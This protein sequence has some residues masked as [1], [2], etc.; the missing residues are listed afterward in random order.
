MYRQLTAF[1]RRFSVVGAFLLVAG[2]AT[3]QSVTPAV[4]AWRE[5][6]EAEITR[7]L[8]AFLA[9][10]NVAS[11]AANIRRNA[12]T[13]RA[14]LERR[15][16]TARLLEN[17][18]APPAVF[19]ELRAP[20]ATRTVMFYAHYDGQ[21]VSA[22]EWATP[23]WRPVLRGPPMAGDSLA[24]PIPLPA[25]GRL[26]PEA[27]LYARSASDDKSPIIAM[28]AALDALKAA[29]VAP[30][31]NL[32]FFFEGEEEAG[33]EHLRPL[34]ERNARLLAADVWLFCDGPVHQSRKMQVVF[35]ARGVMGLEMTVYGPSRALHSG[36]YGNWAPNPGAL[37]AE[38]IASMRDGDGN[39][40]IERFLDDVVP[41]TT[42]ERA[43]VRALP[44][45]DDALR[46][47]LLIGGSEAAGA[48][49][50]E[51]ILLPA[52]NVRGIRA[53]QVGALANNAVPTEARASFDFRMVP[54]QTPERVRELVEA[55][56]TKRGWFIV[57]EEPTAAERL[58]HAKVVRLEW[59][60]G[61][62]SVR[63]LM[64]LAVSRAVLGV[65]SEAIGAP[66]LALPTLG[67]SLPLNT[68][69]EVL[70]VP[71]ITVPIVNHD[72]NQHAKDEN[73]RLQNL[74]DGIEV[75]AALMARLGP[76]WPGVVP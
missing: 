41:P 12:E 21:P 14:M 75:F 57:R 6:H 5:R 69:A 11:D 29:G 32:K 53:G 70:K 38:L 54:R 30:S 47:S 74:W 76:A 71:L 68:F 34:L 73:L 19:G 2:S 31:V 4:R 23:P 49:L 20:G 67:G 65:V 66:V 72:N 55:H 61:Y 22:S 28:L 7:E 39:I 36:H 13:L 26:D 43:A 25:G 40:L 48:L 17:G 16:I 62:P 59:E 46:R 24:D 37:L 33:S 44:P 27:R 60:G 42:A 9:I 56:V 1:G 3:A 64:D 35:G 45:T 10:P 58:A 63:T 50:F 51:R 18:A 15:G 52:V 8:V